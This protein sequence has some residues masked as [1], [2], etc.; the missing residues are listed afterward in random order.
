M[1]KETN[2]LYMFVLIG[3]ANVGKTSLVNKWL[4]NDYD[5]NCESTQGS[6]FADKV[7]SV[8]GERVKIQVW[9]TS[10]QERFEALNEM[11][12]RPSRAV[13]VVFALDDNN[14]FEYAQKL[15]KYYQDQSLT[16]QFVLVGTKCDNFQTSQ[17]DSSKIVAFCAGKSIRYYATSA[18]FDLNVTQLFEE[19]A[20]AVYERANPDSKKSTTKPTESLIKKS[21][22]LRA[23]LIA[24]LG[25]YIQKKEA[26]QNGTDGYSEGFWRIWSFFGYTPKSRALNRR[27]NHLLAQQL[28]RE[29]RTTKTISDIFKD[30]K[31][32][33]SGIITGS[34]IRIQEGYREQGLNCTSELYGIVEDAKK[35][36]SK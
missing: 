8:N 12:V 4:K 9:D 11:Y 34:G 24:R 35:T 19:T 25:T 3:Q 20:Q 28:L 17:V 30:V 21:T 13:I 23:E 14:S 10:G 5:D 33:R 22:D 27:A 18:K 1:Q 31:Q 29:L 6:W 36:F 15:L 2:E 26:Q 7:V 32:A 16:S